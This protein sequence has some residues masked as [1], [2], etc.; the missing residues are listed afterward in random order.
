MGLE[1]YNDQIQHKDGKQPNIPIEKNEEMLALYTI[2][3]SNLLE[4]LCLKKSSWHENKSLW[5][6]WTVVMM[7]K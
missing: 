5:T 1:V 4:K 6:M 7:Y 2:R 3:A